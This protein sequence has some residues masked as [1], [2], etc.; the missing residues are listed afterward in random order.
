MTPT[1][2]AHSDL[3]AAFAERGP[4][5]RAI[6]LRTL[7]SPWDA[8]DAVQETWLRLQRARVGE[9]AN[10]DAWLT[11]VV[12]RVC[13]DQL[14]ARGARHEDIGA[15]LPEEEGPPAA[16]PGPEDSALRAE[17]VAEAMLVVV[18][19]LAPLERL[20]LVLHDV[21]G[22][23]FDEIAPVVERTPVAARQLASRARR[24]IRGVD[25]AAERA[26]RCD[27]VDAFLKA[28]R[29]GDFGALLQALDPEVELRADAEAI[30]AAARGADDGAPLLR[31]RVRGADAVA[32]AFAGR[33]AETR[34]AL[35]D[36]APGAAYAPEGTPR[37]VYAVALR[38]GRIARIDI[39]AHAA[40][41][42]GV[43]VELR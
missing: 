17:E 2:G 36:G 33:A 7:G 26:R 1:T 28:S 43:A 29:E 32:R 21:F 14:R 15:E 6:A 20:A 5:L 11:T 35:L 34:V 16:A 12:A 41:L 18:D 9:I 24:R 40:R 31:S 22:L 25:V 39:I 27:A 8:D 10:L 13:V 37:A 23:S 42:S 38:N 3:A 4:R 30:A 19:A